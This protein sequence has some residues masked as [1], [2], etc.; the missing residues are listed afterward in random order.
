MFGVRKFNTSCF[1]IGC[2]FAIDHLKIKDPAFCLCFAF[3]SRII[4]IIASHCKCSAVVAIVN[5]KK[6][7]SRHEPPISL[8]IHVIPC[9]SSS[10]PHSFAYS[11]VCR[12]LRHLQGGRWSRLANPSVSQITFYIAHTEH[13][14]PLLAEVERKRRRRSNEAKSVNGC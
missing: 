3:S 1:M 13:S 6:Q 8:P 14:L 7:A 2:E 4:F 12:S 10:A 11:S 5:K 9:G